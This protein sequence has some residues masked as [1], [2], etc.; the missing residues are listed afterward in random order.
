VAERRAAVDKLQLNKVAHQ[1]VAA[2][3]QWSA[4]GTLTLRQH[5]WS[6]NTAPDGFFARTAMDASVFAGIGIYPGLYTSA[7]LTVWSDALGPA[8]QRTRPGEPAEVYLWN[9]SVG[10]NDGLVV[11]E[12][13]RFRGKKLPGIPLLDGAQL[14]VRPTPSIEVG[15]YGGL[16]P[17]LVTV[18]PGAERVTGG[19]YAAFDW[20]VV[21]GLLLLPRVRVAALSTPD[22]AAVRGEVEAQTLV[23]WAGVGSLGGSVRSS[24]GTDGVPTLDA[25]RVD[26]DLAPLRELRLSAGYRYLA[27]PVFDLDLKP[28]AEGVTPVG[29]VGGHHHGSASASYR[30]ADW[31][32]I[33]AL[34]GAALDESQGIERLWVG[35]ELRV[36]LGIGGVD[37]GYLE[38]LGDFGGRS[39]WAGGW[40]S[41]FSILRLAGRLSYFE[42]NFVGDASRET[43]FLFM[44][45]APVLPWLTLRGRGFVLQGL[46]A[47]DG[48]AR[49]QPTRVMADLGVSASF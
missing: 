46:P 14:G 43:T 44:A 42:N 23:S 15:A 39:G 33:G 38:E 22:F 19:L 29:L 13:G 40:V 24:V 2:G 21:D 35:P 34:S 45:D 17:D 18:Y 5:L 28:P 11:G 25:G 9:A 3:A 20:A 37:F 32:S 12:L 41:P 8:T 47:L 26:F 6:T 7:A 49:A 48:A 1:K 10:V 36:P 30:V 27:T 4:R 16:I 31:L